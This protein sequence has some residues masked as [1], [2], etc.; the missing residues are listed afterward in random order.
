ML[1]LADEPPLSE[2]ETW[3]A[4]AR[5]RSVWPPL[6][7]VAD[8][9][10]DGG[11]RCSLRRLADHLQ[12]HVVE[13]AAGARGL[14]DCAMSLVSALSTPGLVGVHV[15]NMRTLC[16][17]ARTGHAAVLGDRGGWGPL[18]RRPEIG[19]VLLVIHASEHVTL[20]SISEAVQA[21]SSLL[22][23]ESEIMLA[24]PLAVGARGPAL[25]LSFIAFHR[26]LG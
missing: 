7:F 5:S 25:E 9:R 6:A 18:L 10:R 20:Q 22:P 11:D 24:V 3:A 12:L 16:G 19:D 26:D 1:D 23:A 2:L 4:L 13:A 21:V 15:E 14:V 17:A 8:S